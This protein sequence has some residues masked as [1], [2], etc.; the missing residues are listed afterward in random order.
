MVFGAKGL[1]WGKFWAI[2][3]ACEHTL[4]QSHTYLDKEYDIQYQELKT[5]ALILSD[6]CVFGLFYTIFKLS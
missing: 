2:L 3:L 1:T 5:T 4:L 6:V